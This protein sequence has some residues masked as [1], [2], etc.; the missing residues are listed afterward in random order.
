MEE[1]NWIVLRS[2]AE[3]RVRQKWIKRI[4]SRFEFCGQRDSWWIKLR[5]MKLL[6]KHCVVWLQFSRHFEVQWVWLQESIKMR[7]TV[8]DAGNNYD[9]IKKDF[10][11]AGTW[12]HFRKSLRNSDKYFL[13]YFK[14][15]ILRQGFST[16]F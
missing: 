6:S 10:C 8:A 14:I 16:I 7:V 1:E 5:K 4:S 3:Y 2:R 12:Y 9:V 13:L 15:R 11:R